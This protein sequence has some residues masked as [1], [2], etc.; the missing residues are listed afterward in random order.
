[1]S[2]RYSGKP[3]AILT[4]HRK[5]S[6][7]RPILEP[8]LGCQIA[9]ATG[10]DTDQLGTFS[11]EIQRLDTQLQTARAKARI[12][13]RLMG[14][15]IGIASEGAFGPDPFGG[16]MPWNVEVLIWIDDDSQLEMVGVAQGPARHLQRTLKYWPELETF[17]IEAGFPEHHLML[18][19]ASESDPRIRK[20]LSD[21]PSLRR[22]FEA[23]Q[24][25]ADNRL[26]H[27]ENDLRSMGNPT[28]QHMIRRAC[29]N[30]LE[31]I[32]SS[33][34]QCAMPGFSIVTHRAGL[35]CRWCQRPTQLAQ[36]YVWSCSLCRHVREEPVK[37]S[38][39]EPGL[40]HHCNP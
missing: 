3:V 28:R 2:Q 34:P 24:R 36:S 6:L 13:M 9:L 22:A 30:L 12:G 16:L 8:A 25:E 7:V 19:P 18:R 31:K 33:C 32:Q 37:S 35:P 5:E 21:W 23:G 17:A 38:H 20:G 26:V 11:G 29:V 39:A 4:Q 10:Y 27:V 40:C 14:A 15:S 1:M